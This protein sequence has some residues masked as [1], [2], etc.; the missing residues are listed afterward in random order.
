MNR[1]RPVWIVLFTLGCGV[2]PLTNPC[3]EENAVSTGR[4]SGE[5]VVDVSDAQRPTFT[6][7]D[8]E[9][10]PT[11][12][13]LWEL[14]DERCRDFPSRQIWQLSGFETEQLPLVYG[15][16][17]Q[18]TREL[19]YSDLTGDPAATDAPLPLQE[20]TL[21]EVR[22]NIGGVFEQP[23]LPPENW[24]ATFLPG[25]PDS[26]RIGG[27]LCGAPVPSQNPEEN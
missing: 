14:V 9:V 21:Y 5:I 17:P 7:S 23:G 25:E 10:P 3:F 1:T 11:R 12:V 26:V 6:M 4:C 24:S 19:T 8:V 2:G 13:E 16:P 22:F 20:G 18:G 15:V 27:T